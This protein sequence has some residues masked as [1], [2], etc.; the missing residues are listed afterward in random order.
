MRIKSFENE[1]RYVCNAHADRLV[2][3]A[4]LLLF[5]LIT[6]TSFTYD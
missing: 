4:N 2:Q 5:K 3:F 1:R 6:V